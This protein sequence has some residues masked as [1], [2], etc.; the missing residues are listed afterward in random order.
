MPLRAITF[1]LWGTIIHDQDPPEKIAKR[2]AIILDALAE[3]GH[4]FE[5]EEYRAGIRAAN[6]IAKDRIER[7]RVDIGPEQRWNLVTQALGI[8]T[9]RVPFERIAPAYVDLTVEF[10]PPLLPAIDKVLAAL[11]GRVKIGLICNTGFTGGEPLRQV[12]EIHE[13]ARYFDVLTFSNEFGYLKPDPRIFKHTLE[14]LDVS[15]AEALHVGDIEDAD[16]A[17][18]RSV[19][20]FAARYAPEVETATEGH[21]L[22]RDWREFVAQIGSLDRDA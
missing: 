19:G 3:A 8:P 22:V 21:L 10:L 6:R 13:L 15:A 11:H 7:E 12:L 1:D 4:P 17:G 2:R 18:A 5:M 9:G 20:M 16:V 14:Q